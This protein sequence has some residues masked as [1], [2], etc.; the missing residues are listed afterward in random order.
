MAIV[1]A[2]EEGVDKR[3]VHMFTEN[4]LELP[5]R[6]R[7]GPLARARGEHMQLRGALL[8]P[9]LVDAEMI[10]PH[11]GLQRDLWTHIA[12][13]G[14]QRP[15]RLRVGG[16]FLRQHKI[17]RLHQ[18]G[19]ASLVRPADD[20]HTGFWEVLDLQVIHAPDII[21]FNRM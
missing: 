10:G 8:H 18:C 7:T 21:E 12:A 4:A 16:V 20:H 6:F 14:L 1:L 17:N 5:I 9:P 11:G 2:D 3:A 15:H 13:G 19:F